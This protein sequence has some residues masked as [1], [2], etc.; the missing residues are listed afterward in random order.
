MLYN[1]LVE[2]DNGVPVIIGF[3]YFDFPG[4]CI[5][6]KSFHEG[7]VRAVIPSHDSDIL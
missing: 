1:R 3:Q 4:D 6:Q 5:R 7:F 2:D